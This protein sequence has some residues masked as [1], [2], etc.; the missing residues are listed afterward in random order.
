MITFLRGIFLL[1][2]LPIF[3]VGQTAGFVAFFFISG[4]NSM[5]RALLALGEDEEEGKE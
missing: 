5:T 4:F 1:V 3:F 2:G